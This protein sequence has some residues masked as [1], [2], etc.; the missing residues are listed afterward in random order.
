MRR[1][2]LAAVFLACSLLGGG[3]GAAPKYDICA[4]LGP[5]LGVGVSSFSAA[6]NWPAE[7]EQQHGVDWKFL[8]LYVVPTSDP[9]ADVESF[10]LGK[11]SLAKSH[12][13]IPV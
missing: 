13:A 10:L 3:A 11:A 8:Y 4:D 6:G 12:G 1:L 7:A 2:A 5:S 9:K